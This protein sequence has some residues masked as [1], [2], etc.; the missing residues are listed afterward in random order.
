MKCIYLPE[1]EIPDEPEEIEGSH[2]IPQME[3]LKT[4]MVKRKKKTPVLFT[5][6]F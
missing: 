2:Y 3:T 1:N 4:H 5:L 6:I